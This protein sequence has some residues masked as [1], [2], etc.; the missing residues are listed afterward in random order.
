MRHIRRGTT[1]RRQNLAMRL[2]IALRDYG[3]FLE[4]FDS[5]STTAEPWQTRFRQLAAILRRGKFPDFDKEKIFCIGLS[6]TGTMSL[7]AALRALGYLTAHYSNTFTLQ[8]LSEDDA[9][10]FEAMC[11][12]PVCIRFETLYHMFPNAKFIYTLRSYETWLP[13]FE[14][15]CLRGY[16]TTDFNVIRKIPSIRRDVPSISDFEAVDCALYFRFPDAMSAYENYDTRVRNFFRDKPEA[17]LLEYDVFAGQGW[18]KLCHFLR[19][20]IPQ[21]EYPWENRTCRKVN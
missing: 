11:D 10:I 8:M 2:L 20:P 14:K 3:G 9:F 17:K 15:H 18:Q 7:A 6:K 1:A 16:G 4:I 13:S 21:I 12:T 19:R 5:V